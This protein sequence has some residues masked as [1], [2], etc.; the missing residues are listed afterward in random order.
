MLIVN[1]GSP[2]SS[3]G[4]GSQS[5]DLDVGDT[6]IKLRVTAPDDSTTIADYDITVIRRAHVDSDD[7][8]LSAI[9]APQ[10]ATVID[11]TIG[12]GDEF[13]T[14]VTAYTA[15][16]ANSVNSVE[17]TATAKD[18]D[19]DTAGPDGAATVEVRLGDDK[20]SPFTLTVGPNVIAIEVTAEDGTTTKL[21][22]ITV[23]RLATAGTGDASLSSLT[24]NDTTTSP[25]TAIELTPTFSRLHATYTA[26]VSFDTTQVTAGAFTPNRVL[27]RPSR[28]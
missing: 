27:E 25:A 28:R 1:N 16:V 10:L 23:T 14:K 7:T 8:S 2:G 26:E 22:T 18:Q 6:F 11:P 24:I 13:D 20:T 3:S 17:V 12:T 5:V 9:Q 19:T 4:T 15:T 21:Y